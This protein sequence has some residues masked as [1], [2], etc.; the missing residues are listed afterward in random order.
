MKWRSVHWLTL[1]ERNPSRCNPAN[2]GITTILRHN[3]HSNNGMATMHSAA[4]NGRTDWSGR[5]ARNW[6]AGSDGTGKLN[7][8]VW[9]TDLRTCVRAGSLPHP[10][11]HHHHHLHLHHHL[12]HTHSS[13]VP[14]HVRLSPLSQWSGT[15]SCGHSL[16]FRQVKC[17]SF[18]LESTRII[19]EPEMIYGIIIVPGKCVLTPLSLTRSLYLHLYL[20][21]PT[22]KLYWGWFI[23]ITI[24]GDD[25]LA[26]D[27]KYR[28]WLQ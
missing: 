15:W 13:P 16:K 22:E 6:T 10:A 9:S 19:K 20:T 18:Y 1:Q 2:N 26:L 28:K 11:R 23:S 24:Q 8:Q 7:W 17:G 14:V 3:N 25:E 5:V 27:S 4:G 12:S 21:I